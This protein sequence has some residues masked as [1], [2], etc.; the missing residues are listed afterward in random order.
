[1]TIS[2]L[3]DFLDK[4]YG[5]FGDEDEGHDVPIEICRYNAEQVIDRVV[6]QVRNGPKVTIHTADAGQGG[7]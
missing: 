7:K 5:F 6:F 2:E 4:C 3:S 1:M